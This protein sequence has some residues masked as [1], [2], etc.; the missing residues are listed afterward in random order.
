VAERTGALR[1][2]EEKY[3]NL[4][5][6][7]Q[8]GMYRSTLDGSAMLEVNQK[9]A[10]VFGYSV[11]EMLASPATMRWAD[12]AARAEMVRHAAGFDYLLMVMREDPAWQASEWDRP[13]AQAAQ[14]QEGAE[15]GEL[16]LPHRH[17][18]VSALR[19]QDPDGEVQREREARLPVR[20]QRSAAAD[21]VRD[22]GRLA[23]GRQPLDLG[24]PGGE[25]EREV[26]LLRRARRRDGAA[27]LPTPRYSWTDVESLDQQASREQQKQ[28][29]HRDLERQ[30]RAASPRSEVD[31]HQR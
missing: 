12:P 1:E 24:P 28:H 22:P 15:R 9:L 21:A 18:V 4:F 14:E 7:A 26:G 17:H 23:P 25:L 11:E 3:R 20:E 31:Q 30:Y 2:S 16:Q 10:Q 19:A 27:P 8:V 6:N 5:S 29:V 13:R